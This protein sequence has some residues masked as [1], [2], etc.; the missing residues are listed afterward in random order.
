[1]KRSSVWALLAFSLLGSVCRTEA[2]LVGPWFRYPYED[3]GFQIPVS[4]DWEMTPVDHGVVFAMQYAPDPYV[5]VAIGRVNAKDG[6]FEAMIASHLQQ[7]LP[8]QFRRAGCQVDGQNA[9]QIEGINEQGPFRDVFIER[10][11]YVYWI[12]FAAERKDLWPQYSETFDIILQGFH[13][14]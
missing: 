6:D 1:V 13:F 8:G 3:L 11:R 9:V 14:I 10:D 2:S 4:S 12:G 5:R 7:L